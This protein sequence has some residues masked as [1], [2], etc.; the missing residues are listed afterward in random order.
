MD[1]FFDEVE[2]VT[3]LLVASRLKPSLAKR[4]SS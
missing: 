2:T 4:R 1:V 3:V